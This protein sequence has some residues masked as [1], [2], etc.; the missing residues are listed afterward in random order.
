M[1]TTQES[2]DGLELEELRSTSNIIRTE[3]QSSDIEGSNDIESK[4]SQN[5]ISSDLRLDISDVTYSVTVGKKTKTLL[6]SLNFT[7]RAGEMVAVLGRSGSG[8][9]TLLD[10]MAGRTRV[11]T[12]SGDILLNGS[13]RP[14][15]Y[16]RMTA[17]VLQDDIFIPNLT[18]RRNYLLL[19]NY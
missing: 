19:Y 16:N 14:E 5:N 17:Y 4:L 8:K 9:T 10:L 12:L 15:W 6:Q 3:T 7:V 1:K 13:E 11:G 2:K 18:G